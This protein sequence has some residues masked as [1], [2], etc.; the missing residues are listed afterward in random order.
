MS[1]SHQLMIDCMS[2]CVI[3]WVIAWLRHC[4]CGSCLLTRSL[5]QL[6]SARLE[7]PWSHAS[8][9]LVPVGPLFL[10]PLFLLSDNVS[11]HCM[12]FGV[13]RC[14]AQRSPA[15]IR[16]G[17]QPRPGSRRS[18][19]PLWHSAAPSPALDHSGAALSIFV[20]ASIFHPCMH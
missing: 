6:A 20:V 3:A 5:S 16:N 11:P 15:I 8:V 1:L 17:A 10:T 14:Q 2:D 7:R 4:V 13:R 9:R 18:A 12:L 19:Q